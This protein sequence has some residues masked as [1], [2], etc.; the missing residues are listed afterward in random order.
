M[1]SLGLGALD[2][3]RV[4]VAPVLS[5]GL[6]SLRAQR[7]LPLLEPFD[8]SLAL[9]GV[10]LRDGTVEDRDAAPGLRRP[11]RPVAG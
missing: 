1:P 9:V 8:G 2:P 10:S 4:E 11:A 3:Q 7:L 6:G 5:L